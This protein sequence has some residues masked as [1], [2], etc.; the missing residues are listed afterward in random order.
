V[1]A[2]LLADQVELGRRPVVEVLAAA[3]QVDRD[4]RLVALGRR[5]DDVLRPERR[6]AAEEDLRQR[7]LQGLFV[8]HRHAP[9]VELEA[10]VALDPGEGVLLADRDQHFVAG[11]WNSSGSPVGIRLR[12]PLASYSARTISNSTPVSLP[13]SWRNSL[14]TRMLRMGMPSWMASSFS[15]GEAFISS[16]PLRTMTLTSLAAQAPRRAAAVHRGV[17]A[18]EHDDA[19]R[20]LRRMAESDVGQPVDADVDVRRGFLAAR[21]SRRIAPARRAGA[22]EDRVPALAS[23]P[24][25][26]ATHW[27]KCAST[28]RSRM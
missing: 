16:K 18:A 15:Q 28:P 9:L 17:A 14:G 24:S 26:C 5:G 8:Q 4:R 7:R 3:E 22:D 13:F 1:D 23:S 2:H 21:E 11:S 20:D 19:L 25:G 6:V 27:L 10:D 12:R